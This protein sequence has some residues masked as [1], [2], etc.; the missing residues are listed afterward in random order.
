[1]SETLK[2]KHAYG[3]VI[4]NRNFQH[5]PTFNELISYPPT[6]IFRNDPAFNENCY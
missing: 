3:N 5:I 2:V 1:M 6:H 4:L